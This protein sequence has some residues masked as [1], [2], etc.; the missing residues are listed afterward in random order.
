M[1]IKYQIRDWDMHYENSGSRQV[2]HCR[3]GCIPNKQNGLPYKRTVAKEETL[4]FYAGFVAIALL[5]SQNRRPRTGWLTDTGAEDGVPYTALDIHLKT[6]VPEKVIEGTLSHFS[7]PAIMGQKTWLIRF[8][9]GNATA[10]PPEPSKAVAVDVGD[11][12]AAQPQAAQEKPEKRTNRIKFSEEKGIYG[13][14]EAD[15]EEWA[16]SYPGL[17][18]RQEIRALS[19]WAKDNPRKRPKKAF[20]AFLSRNFSRKQDETGRGNSTLDEIKASRVKKREAVERTTQK[21]KDD[22]DILILRREQKRDIPG[23]WEEMKERYGKNYSTAKKRIEDYAK[24]QS[25]R[26]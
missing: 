8:E 4:L 17:N 24:S 5:Q 19:Q 18:I 2:D 22:A 1:E 13:Y 20:A 16:E 26:T 25:S 21:L 11:Q 7:D 23:F 14:T 9:D 12:G 6:G 10:G 3:W 15:I